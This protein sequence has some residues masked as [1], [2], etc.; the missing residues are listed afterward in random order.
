LVQLKGVRYAVIQEPSK[1]DVIKEGP[2]KELTG[3]DPIQARAP[4]MT[5]I[6]TYTPQFK[7][8]LC[9]NTFMEIKVTDHGTWRRIRV[10]D[11]ESLFTENPVDN[12]PEK[13]YQYQ[14][15]K[16]IKD[17]FKKWRTVFLAMLVERA[18]KTNGVVEDCAKVLAASNSYRESQDCIAEFIAD[19]I[20]CSSKGTLSKT[21]VVSAFREWYTQNY[22]F[23][24]TSTKD[25]TAYLDKKFGKN[26][27]GVWIGVCLKSDLIEEAGVASPR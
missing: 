6:I 9:S 24:N 10:A 27:S 13:P 21:V 1:G 12:D 17:K 15:D 25:I 18:F 22:G 8:V 26:C 14:L 20:A 23:K 5:K 4:Y 7:L 3:G 11:F 16:T 2:M 19:K